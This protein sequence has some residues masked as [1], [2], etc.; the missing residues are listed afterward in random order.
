MNIVKLH[1]RLVVPTLRKFKDSGQMVAPCAIARIGVQQYLAK[2]LG[3]LFKDR[4]PNSIVVVMRRE[5]DVFCKDSIESMFAAPITVGHPKEGVD[6][7]NAK[8]LVVGNLLG[9]P[10]RSGDELV[11]TLVLNDKDAIEMVESGV[12]G[13]S[14]GYT[15]RIVRVDDE[16]LPYDAIQTHIRANHIAIVKKPRGD[17][18]IADE[19]SV[20]P[21]PKLAAAEPETA[22]PAP[23]D[24]PPC[25]G[26][27]AGESEPEATPEAAVEPVIADVV[28][29][30]DAAQADTVRMYDQDHVDALEAQRDALVVKLADAEARILDAAA[31][32][33][34]VK[35]RMAFMSEV[36]KISDADIVGMNE[37]EAKRK[38]VGLELGKDVSEKSDAYIQARYEIILED[39]DSQEDDCSIGD[40]LKD[41]VLKVNDNSYVPPAMSARERMIKR[42]EGKV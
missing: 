21:D 12:S 3:D 8:E 18:H 17:V 40:M 10:E 14:V 1:D 26:E 30:A 15:S 25:D 42:N 38:V 35:E 16:S 32:D 34:L 31:I 22:V 4:D 5:E 39:A 41:Q 37:I 2:E 7:S 24:Q 36:A 33:A 6:T 13:L 19:A 29:V 28:A 9:A 11:G 20:E 23:V 27:G